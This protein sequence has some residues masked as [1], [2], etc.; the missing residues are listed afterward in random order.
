[1]DTFAGMPPPARPRLAWIDLLRGVA[2][3]GMIETHVMNTFLHAWVTKTL[4]ALQ[5]S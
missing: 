2:L 3:V 5:G 1:M 4:R